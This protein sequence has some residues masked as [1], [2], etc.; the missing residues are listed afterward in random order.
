MSGEAPAAA[1]A[2][3]QPED[4]IDEYN[5]KLIRIQWDRIQRSTECITV[6]GQPVAG[7]CGV[8]LEW[9]GGGGGMP[10]LTVRQHVIPKP[11]ELGVPSQA[12]VSGYLV[13]VDLWAEYQAWRREE[14]DPDAPVT[15]LRLQVER[16]RA[17]NAALFKSREQWRESTRNAVRVSQQLGE[18]LDRLHRLHGGAGQ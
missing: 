3:P 18:E 7:V 6:N 12:E 14:R 9:P 1:P 13:P 17:E 4:W 11:G 15:E 16:L 2:T 5:A 8:R 10:L